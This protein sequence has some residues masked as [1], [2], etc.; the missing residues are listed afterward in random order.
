V[1]APKTTAV[2]SPALSTILNHCGIDQL[3]RS[4]SSVFDRPEQDAQFKQTHGM[5]RHDWDAALSLHLHGDLR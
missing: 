2:F 4:I 1:A 3:I 5:N